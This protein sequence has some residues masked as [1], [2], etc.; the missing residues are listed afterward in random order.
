M[1]VLQYCKAPRHPASITTLK[2]NSY[3]ASSLQSHSMPSRPFH[4]QL[5]SINSSI[6]CQSSNFIDLLF[7]K[8]LSWLLLLTLPPHLMFCEYNLSFRCDL[9]TSLALQTI[10]SFTQCWFVARAV[11][12][13][14]TM[15][16]IDEG[17]SLFAGIHAAQVD[18]RSRTKGPCADSCAHVPDNHPVDH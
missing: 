8:C 6:L 10:F 7:C 9:M 17:C 18:L 12:L 4:S 16:R 5:H 14:L 1:S 13:I 3:S 15:L 2:C 11:C